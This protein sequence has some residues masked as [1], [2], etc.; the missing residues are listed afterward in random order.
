MNS[1]QSGEY[2]WIILRWEARKMNVRE[3]D[4]GE[5]L[6]LK[7]ELYYGA[8]ICPKMTE[9]QKKICDE[10]MYVDDIPDELVFELYDGI[11]FVK[12]DFWIN[13]PSCEND[14]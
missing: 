2:K 8:D 5:L 14:D 11:E 3:L 12:E 13:L 4:F 7:E 6:Q 9:E 10:A 1:W